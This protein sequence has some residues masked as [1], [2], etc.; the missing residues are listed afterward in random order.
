MNEPLHISVEPTAAWIAA[1]RDCQHFDGQCRLGDPNLISATDQVTQRFS[2]K[3]SYDGRYVATIVLSTGT[4]LRGYGR[5]G[6]EAEQAA[7]RVLASH[8]AARQHNADVLAR[9]RPQVQP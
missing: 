7:E 4:R 6:F 3:R 2:R 9:R 8:L 5:T 1:H